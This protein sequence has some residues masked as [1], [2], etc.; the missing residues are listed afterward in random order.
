MN[1]TDESGSRIPP[2]EPP[3]LAVATEPSPSPES[4]MHAIFMGPNGMRAGWRLLIFFAIVAALFFAVR[5]AVHLVMHATGHAAASLPGFTMWTVLFNE[6]AQFTLI[7]IASWIMTKIERRTI[8]DYGLPARR[9]FCGQFWQGSL[10]GFIGISALLIVLRLA[11]AFSFGDLALH[12]VAIWKCGAI[13]G[14]AFLFVGFFEEFSIRGYPLFTLATGIGFWPA[15]LFWSFIFGLGHYFNHG[16]TALGA[17]SA[18]AFGFLFCLILRRTGDLWLPIGFH[19][20][21]DW[22]ETYFYGVPDS[23]L[24]AGG[25]LLNASFHGPQW[26]TGGTVGPEA[27]WLCIALLVIFWFLFNAWFR[28]V[29]YPNPAA[30]PDPRARARRA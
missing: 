25:H 29:K 15:A 12:G 24:V 20:G 2:G 19:L 26:L 17:F 7:L 30:I 28:D 23:G 6:P 9:A 14:V 13:W 22:G 16:E 27:R 10:I 5:N 21:W 4:S 1:E 8:A 11:G 3:T 18:G